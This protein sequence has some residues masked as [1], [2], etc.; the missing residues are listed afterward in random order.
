APP[1]LTAAEAL[2]AE[3]GGSILRHVQRATA[4]ARHWQILLLNR[5]PTRPTLL[6]E[7]RRKSSALQTGA[8]SSW[9]SGTTAS[10]PAS[11]TTLAGIR[12][13]PGAANAR[14]TRSFAHSRCRFRS[15]VRR[16]WTMAHRVA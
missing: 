14:R 8:T 15:P 12:P 3:L 1:A 4:W 16:A 6:Q 13:R 5:Q 2:S 11:R 10:T 9:L 7:N